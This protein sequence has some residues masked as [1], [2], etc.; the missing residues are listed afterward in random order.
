MTT[1]EAIG[2]WEAIAAREGGTVSAL[3]F[4]PS[5]TNDRT[6]FAATLAGV[7]RSTDGGAS[8]R[9]VS[10]GLASPFVDAIAVS[11][12]YAGDRTVFAGGREGGVSRST[13]GGE[14]WQPLPFVSTPP[15]SVTAL[16][17]SSSYAQ[18]GALFAGAENG[19]VYRTTDRGRSWSVIGD[20]L[21][22]A[23]VLGL[24]SA[25]TGQGGYSLFALTP[26]GLFRSDDYGGRWTATGELP[27]VGQAIRVSNA[28]EI[29]QTIYIGT[30]E[31][32]VLRSTDAGETWA[33]V[34]AGLTDLCVNGLALSPAYM[35]DQIVFAAAADGVYRS[36]DR[37]ESWVQYAAGIAA[38]CIAVAPPPVFVPGLDLSPFAEPD[39]TLQRTVL[40]GAVDAGVYRSVNAGVDWQPSSA[41]LSA[42]MLVALTVSPDFAR[43]G[44]LLACGLED[45]ISRSTDGG[46]TWSPSNEGLATMQV[47]GLAIAP[48]IAES[49]LAAAATAAGVAISRDRGASW[50]PT[51]PAAAAQTV[52]IGAGAAGSAI[53]AGG[54][55]GA[56]HL[57]EDAGANWQALTAPFAGE[58]I[59][60]V[61][62]S[63]AYAADGT[64]FAATSRPEA[65]PRQGR[66]TVW[67][68]QDRGASWAPVMEERSA[69]RWLSLAVPP[70]YARDGAFYVG[71]ADRV[72]RPM[73]RAADSRLSARPR[74]IGEQPGGRETTVVGVVPTPTYAAD[75]TLFAATSTGVYVSRDA[76]L[77][78]QP[79]QA[80]LSD[81][82]IV[83]VAVSPAYAQDRAVFAA[84][85]G[86]AIWRLRDAGPEE[87]PAR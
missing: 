49:G 86:G 52:A 61:A 83:A 8:W 15:P 62:F 7:Y 22:G 84:G 42:R 69:I 6:V 51:G 59:A 76:G 1:D 40:I 44:L 78:W 87:P 81:R 48:D 14:T 5:F 29:D 28:F 82:S 85:L 32:G 65:S 68:S 66:A 54:A 2:H 11:P 57:S 9:N 34:N 38:L 23:P 58:E 56:V 71:I 73:R 27:A 30:E 19:L 72:L 13:D 18:D 50:H 39:M 33:A 77:S 60:M 21:A 45:G 26:A 80:G 31:D 35:V 17:I 12:A 43:D 20:G 53:L 79:L 41:G 63:P 64:L 74:W 24:A 46:L 75:E 47:A 37:G 67:R 4:S 70:T 16:V 36:D 55:A 25:S 10:R 3:A